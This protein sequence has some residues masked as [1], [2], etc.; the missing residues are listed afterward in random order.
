MMTEAEFRFKHSELIESYQYVEFR[1]KGIVS[2]LL[3]GEEKSWFKLLDDCD[4]DPLGILISKLTH[5]QKTETYFGDD[6]IENLHRLKDRRNYWCHK[7]FT[8]I[9]IRVSFSSKTR[10][11]KQNKLGKTLTDDLREAKECEEKLTEAFRRIS[12]EVKL[13]DSLF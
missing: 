12:E 13:V 2:V 8:A 5:C 10:E 1:L 7:C 9:G 6:D 4:N 3:C 11:L